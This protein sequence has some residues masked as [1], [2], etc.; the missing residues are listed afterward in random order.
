M[1]NGKTWLVKTLLVG[2]LL[3]HLSG[4][5]A[6]VVVGG[7]RLI[8]D[9][10]KNEASLT[11]SNRD[12]DTAYLLQSW[13]ENITEGDTRKTPFIITPP[14]FRLNEEQDNIL[15]LIY[16]GSPALPADRESAYWLN[17][18]AIPETTRTDAN[19][20]LIAV[21]SRIKLFY[22]PA[23]LPG[24]AN[25][26]Y[27]ALTWQRQNTR[28]TVSNPT[29]YYVSFNKVN[30]GEAEVANPPMVAPFSSAS[31]TAPA[32]AGPITWRAVNDYG[33]I[34]PAETR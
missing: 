7:T 9:A 34:T 10:G 25:D 30:V 31:M 5:L 19:R 13:T 16:T 24:N 26:A 1:N 14:L 28:L 27:K 18:K 21:R 2:G 33:G 4:A 8:Y 22:R 23:G 29:P 20:L 3:T 6:G 17:T 32:S 11:L 15:R 12:K